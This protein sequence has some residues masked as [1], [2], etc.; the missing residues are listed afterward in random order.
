MAKEINIAILSESMSDKP[1]KPTKSGKDT[2]ALPVLTVLTGNRKD[3]TSVPRTKRTLLE[4]SKGMDESP[5]Q[6][7]IDNQ[8]GGER[9]EME[10]SHNASSL[11][12]MNYT[13][14]WSQKTD[15]WA[16]QVSEEE[17]EDNEKGVSILDTDTEEENKEEKRD[18]GKKS[19][20][21]KGKK[22]EPE[23][24]KKNQ[25]N[26]GRCCQELYVPD[27]VGGSG[28]G[29]GARGL[30]PHPDPDPPSYHDSTNRGV[31]QLCNEEGGYEERGDPAGPGK[32]GRRPVVQRG[33]PPTTTKRWEGARV[34]ILRTREKTLLHL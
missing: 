5:N 28:G 34:P 8:P 24:E 11:G 26:M 29:S 13:I 20:K 3:G 18:E 30:C 9:D 33:G 1:L 21:R 25:G 6:T 16:T 27:N 31:R 19:R 10:T 17:K 7:I 32:R 15:S 2:R 12:D 14:G 4:N 22:I 23:R